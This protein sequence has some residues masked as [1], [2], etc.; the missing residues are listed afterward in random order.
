MDIEQRLQNLEREM[1]E[2]HHNGVV[3][4][5]VE[6][7]DLF[8]V[9]KTITIAGDLTN[10]L[11]TKPGRLIDQILIDTT[12]ATKKLYVYDSVGNV[13]RSVTIA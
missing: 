4:G 3:G 1:K 5:P 12:T 7:R 11:A 9:L 8:G 6:V 2:H 13:W 10:A